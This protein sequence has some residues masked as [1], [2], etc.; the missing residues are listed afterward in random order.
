MKAKLKD[1]IFNE[2]IFLMENKDELMSVEIIE[3]HTNIAK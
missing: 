1:N 2:I 3:I